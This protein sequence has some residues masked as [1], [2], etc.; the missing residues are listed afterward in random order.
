MI[1][2]EK[3]VQELRVELHRT[4][5]KVVVPL[6]ELAAEGAGDMEEMT[7]ETVLNLDWSQIPHKEA[8]GLM[9]FGRAFTKVGK[10]AYLPAVLDAILDPKEMD[11]LPLFFAGIVCAL[12]KSS[13]SADQIATVRAV[14]EFVLSCDEK[15]ENGEFYYDEIWSDREQLLN[16]L[17]D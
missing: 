17:S 7:I 9:D 3:S 4:F 14:T 1:P 8:K 13:L 6:S 10:V 5:P 2:F 15:Y 11:A 16:W 12:D